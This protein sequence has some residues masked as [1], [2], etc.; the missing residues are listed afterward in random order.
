MSVQLSDEPDKFIWNLTT[1]EV[2]TVKSMYEDLMNGH[3]TFLCKYLWRLKIPLKIKF[4]MW[5]L[6]SKVLL[7]KDNLAKR[8]WHGCTKY[9]FCDS[10]ES[11]EHLFLYC[12]F[13]RI[14]WRMIYFTYN[15]PPP[16]NITNMFGNWL[17]GVD[18]NDKARIRIG[19]SALC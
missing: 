7:T 8:N 13:A 18:R 1:N 14:V 19:V 15:I 11:V 12:P 9:C 2:F 17:N 3:T 4:F 6:N 10:M 5:F 16:T